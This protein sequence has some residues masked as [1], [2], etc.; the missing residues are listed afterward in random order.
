M[1]YSSA[2]SSE[3]RVEK[4]VW[5]VDGYQLDFLGQEIYRSDANLIKDFK[6]QLI[7]NENYDINYSGTDFVH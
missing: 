7:V 4:F 5:D 1:S 6:M 3:G 2:W